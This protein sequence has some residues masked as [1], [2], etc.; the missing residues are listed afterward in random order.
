MAHPLDRL[1]PAHILEQCKLDRV[2]FE[3]EL[4]GHAARDRWPEV[5]LYFDNQLLIKDTVKESWK[6]SHNQGIDQGLDLFFQIRYSN[7]GANDTVVND[8]GEIVENQGLVIK[9]L[10][11][12]G[13]NL[14]QSNLIYTLGQYHMDLDP[15]KREYFIAHGFDVGPTHSL[16]MF[17]N[18]HWDLSF[19]TPIN[20]QLCSLKSHMNEYDRP[21]EKDIL[22]KLYDK[23]LGV[24]ELQT[25]IQQLEN[26]IK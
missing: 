23:F 24:R 20:T 19:K 6:W 9:S 21:F 3:I 17:E 2:E 8:L 5:E 25:Q 10:I 11:V 1:I 16:R 13:V 15:F 4:E 12:N 18:G 14:V 26:A 22:Q 7:K